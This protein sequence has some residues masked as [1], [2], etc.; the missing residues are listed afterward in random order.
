MAIRSIVV[1]LILAV[2][3]L[4]ARELASP[5]GFE[6]QMPGLDRLPRE[7]E[8][9]SSEEK[10]MSDDVARALDADETF[11]RVYSDSQGRFVS[12]FLAYFA[13]QQVNSQIHSPRN[14]I[15]GSG[16][17]VV[18]TSQVSGNH[19][20]GEHQA[21]RM[22]IS[23]NESRHFIMYWFRT[24]GGD[25]AGEYSLKWDL[26]KNAIGRQPTNAMFIRF[27]ARVGQ[28]DAMMDVMRQLS[29]P[30]EASLARAGL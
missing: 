24:R 3:G 2:T 30:I 6:L 18:S 15:P 17:K 16:W 12:V 27:H 23:R 1:L 22:V 10:L 26:V 21:T 13:S 8:G 7:L 5:P 14:C 25:L 29:D 4:L 28:E 19:I 11:S 9:W 20:G